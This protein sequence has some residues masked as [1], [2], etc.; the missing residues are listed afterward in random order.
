M[1]ARKALSQLH[2]LGHLPPPSQP[3]PVRAPAHTTPWSAPATPLPRSLEQLG[4]VRLVPIT[5]RRCRRARIW[6]QIMTHHYL[7]AGPLCGHQLRYLIECPQGYLGAL[8]FGAAALHLRPRD[9]AIGWSQTSRRHHLHQVVNNTRFVLLPWVGVPNLASHVLGLCAHVLPA[10]W[11]QRYGCQPVL[12]ESFVDAQRFEGTSYAAAGWQ[13]LGLTTGRGRQDRHHQEQCPKKSIW[14]KP[15]VQ[16]WREQLQATPTV[17][18]LQPPRRA[19]PSPPPMAGS[20]SWAQEE[21]GAADFGD[22]R[23]NRRV[24]ELVRDFAASPQALIP[25][26]CGTRARTL[27]A[28]RFFDHPRVNLTRILAPHRER[29]VQRMQSQA[30][31]LAVQDTTELDYTH[32]PQTQGLGP[33]GN[34]RAQAHG[35]ELHPT[36]AFSLQGVAL[37]LLDAQCWKRAAAQKKRFRR[38]VQEKEGVK[39]L[40]GFAAAEA[41]QVCCPNTCVVSVCDAEADMYELLLKAQGSAS[42]TKLLVRAFRSRLQEDNAQELWTG[43]AAQP[44]AGTTQVH[45]PR[46]GKRPARVAQLSVRFA[47]VQLKAPGYLRGAPPVRLWAI[48]LDETSVSPAGAELVEWLLLTNLP[49]ESFETAVQMTQWYGGRFQI[50]VYFRTLKSGCRIED[51][52]LGT[53]ERLENCLAIDLVVA[54]R[55]MHLSRLARQEAGLGAGRHFDGDEMQVLSALARRDHGLKEG[56]PLSLRDAVRMIAQWGGF[57][58][59]KSDGEPG[60]QTLWRGLLRLDAAVMGFRLARGQAAG[61]VSSNLDYG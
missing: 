51:H 32:H 3:F 54:W 50:E 35:L 17:L 29:T 48:R 46:R 59:R 60:A 30:V 38:P 55:I 58:G 42:G 19:R 9:Q 6:K 23:L 20:K 40:K 5:S 11:Q 28:Y 56:E 39:W 14:I 8:A 41:A 2:R 4:E 13:C 43:L 21:L 26:A 7:G 36:V 12:L 34:H 15:L 52:Q 45:L 16:D 10:Q 49:V 44:V 57:L 31:V 25:E 27:A 18:R 37:G 22:R 1:S 53:R 61:P 33:I 24:I 47:P